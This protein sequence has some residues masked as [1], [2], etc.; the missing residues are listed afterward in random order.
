[1]QR[2]ELIE[3]L[4]QA[5]FVPSQP[6]N[7]LRQPQRPAERTNTWKVLFRNEAAVAE[8]PNVIDVDEDCG[9]LPRIG[10]AEP[11]LGSTVRV[12][13]TS[14]HGPENLRGFLFCARDEQARVMFG[15]RL[16]KVHEVNV[17]IVEL[18]FQA[19]CDENGNSPTP[20]LSTEYAKRFLTGPM[21]TRT[22]M[23]HWD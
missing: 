13:V 6:R 18:V 11:V 15:A 17:G 7:L 23:R 1:M 16:V 22:N 4:R 12:R 19:P 3:T 20:Y 9:E 14:Y 8:I 5:T 21:P 10:F 2:T